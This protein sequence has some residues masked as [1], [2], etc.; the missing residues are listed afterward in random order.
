MHSVHSL[1]D[2]RSKFCIIKTIT[3]MSISLRCVIVHAWS[4]AREHGNSATKSMQQHISCSFFFV[5]VVLFFLFVCLFV[6]VVIV[7][8]CILLAA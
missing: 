8:L 3:L 4:S 6:F 1:R 7:V 2:P 5:V